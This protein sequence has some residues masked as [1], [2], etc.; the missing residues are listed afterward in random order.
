[1]RKQWARY[2]A[3]LTGVFVVFL[4]AMFARIQNPPQP[5]PVTVGETVDRPAPP[6]HDRHR[7]NTD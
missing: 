2:I 7:S 6:A 5:L 4:A 3:L 1:M